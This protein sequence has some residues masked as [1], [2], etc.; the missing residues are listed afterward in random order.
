MNFPN[1]FSFISDVKITKGEAPGTINYTG[2]FTD[3]DASIECIAYNATDLSISKV[4]AIDSKLDKDKVHWFNIT[5]LNNVSMIRS[6]G[7]ALNIH[8]MDLEDIVHVS[9]WSKIEANDDYVFSILK[10]IYLKNTNFIHEH[11]AMILKE[12]LI[13]TFQE[14]PGDI[15]DS[16]RERLKNKTGK[17]REKDSKYLFYILIDALVDEY[18][19]LANQLAYDFGDIEIQILD[20][21]L[22]SK[23]KIYSLRKE[24]VYLS[25]SISPIKNSVKNLLSSPNKVINKDLKPY[26]SDLQEHLEQISDIIRTYK[27]MTNSLHEMQL[28]NISNDMNQTMMTLTI[29]S[30]IFI[31]LSFLAGVFGMN[32]SYIPGLDF[33]SAFFIFIIACTIIATSMLLFFKHKKWY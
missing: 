2:I 23:E 12:N 18:L 9:Q 1:K 19:S 27:E 14:T 5:G 17:V 20:N 29:F 28:S 25:N 21:K 31:P 22:S 24:L 16:I 26:Y 7:K 4:D 11:L 3:I 33:Q 15:F 32:F 8:N 10:M 13:I 30:A 6:I